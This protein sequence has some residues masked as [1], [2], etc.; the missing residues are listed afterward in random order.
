[1]PPLRK[2]IKV[3]HESKEHFPGSLEGFI[4]KNNIDPCDYIGK[5]I[6]K[7]QDYNV[8]AYYLVVTEEFSAAKDHNMHMVVAHASDY[9]SSSS[10]GYA[11]ND[12]FKEVVTD[13]PIEVSIIVKTLRSMIETTRYF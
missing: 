4:K 8:Q 12:I 3:S 2:K 9:G 5:Q 11:I 10:R 13:D 6:I 7:I 1:M